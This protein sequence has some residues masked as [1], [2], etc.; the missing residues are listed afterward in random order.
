MMLDYLLMVTRL[1]KCDVSVTSEMTPGC[2]WSGGFGGY[3]YKY[4]SP[5]GLGLVALY[6][7]LKS[8]TGL[9]RGV[10]VVVVSMRYN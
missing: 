1:S 4:V 10:I 9:S 6:G 3:I 7:R 2:K 5:Y 8:R